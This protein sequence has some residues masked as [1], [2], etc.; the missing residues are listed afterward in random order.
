VE[1]DRRGDAEGC[2]GW[3][4]RGVEGFVVSFVT[5]EG[6]EVRRSLAKTWAVPLEAGRPVRRFRPYKGQKHLPGDW[7]SATDGRLVGFES[8]LERDHLMLLDFDPAVVAIASQPL[9]LFWTAEEGKSRSHAPD[10]FARLRDGSGVVIDCR[11]VEPFSLTEDP[12]QS[13][14][15]LF[16]G[17]RLSA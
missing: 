8:W 7:W 15:R 3:G 10:Y 2:G 13:T 16:P 11:P 17:T 14:R 1:D 9:W 12:W 4:C 6:V 5:A